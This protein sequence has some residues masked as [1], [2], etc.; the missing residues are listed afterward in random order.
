MTD[1][2]D[3]E[4]QIMHCWNIVDDLDHVI[5][6]VLDNEDVLN[7]LLGIKQ[8]YQCKFEKLWKVFEDN[9]RV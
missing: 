4:Q 5:D 2:F 7:L 6:K 1:R 3:L 8:L 9:I